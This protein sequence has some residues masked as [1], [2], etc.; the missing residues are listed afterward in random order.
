MLEAG[1]AVVGGNLGEPGAGHIAP[2]GADRWF[3][4]TQIAA[5]RNFR[6]RFE[7]DI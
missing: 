7:E 6:R 2:V 4:S 1:I 5:P 3:Y